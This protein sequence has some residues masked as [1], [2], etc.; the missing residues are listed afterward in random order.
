MF[1]GFLIQLYFP[2]YHILL[3]KLDNDRAYG[4][5]DTRQAL[6]EAKL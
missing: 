4:I 2:I 1:I 6:I 3:K 5:E